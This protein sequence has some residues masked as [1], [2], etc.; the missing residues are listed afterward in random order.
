MIFNKIK[1]DTVCSMSIKLTLY[2]CSITLYLLSVCS[3]TL[4]FLWKYDPRLIS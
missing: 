2:L 3:M 1:V 4:K